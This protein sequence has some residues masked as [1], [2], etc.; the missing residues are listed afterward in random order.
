MPYW[1]LY[2]SST[3][4][5]IIWLHSI[6]TDFNIW[7]IDTIASSFESNFNLFKIFW[8]S[9]SFWIF[10][11][12]SFIEFKVLCDDKYSLIWLEITW[13]FTYKMIIDILSNNHTNKIYILLHFFRKLRL[14]TQNARFKAI[15]DIWMVIAHVFNNAKSLRFIYIELFELILR[16]LKMF[17]Y[18]FSHVVQIRTEF[19]LFLILFL[20]ILNGL[21]R[22]LRCVLW[23]SIIFACF[24]LSVLSECIRFAI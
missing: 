10:L 14:Y 3:S 18:I 24:I 9:C 11:S 17:F 7:Y 16:S 19:I 2:T 8:I 12:L 15:D 20:E 6:S 13:N 4:N 5:A 23:L 21:L 1:D 22:L